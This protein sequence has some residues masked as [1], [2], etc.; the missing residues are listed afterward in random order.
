LKTVNALQ[1]IKNN[2]Y[3]C[4]LLPAVCCSSGSSRLH[5]MFYFRV[6]RI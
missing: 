6:H 2:T 3:V 1:H 5:W 4:I